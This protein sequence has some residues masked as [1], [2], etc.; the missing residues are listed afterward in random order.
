MDQKDISTALSIVQ[1]FTKKSLNEKKHKYSKGALQNLNEKL[2]IKKDTKDLR[3]AVIDQLFNWAKQYKKA[4]PSAVDKATEDLKVYS[5]S[6]GRF[7]IEI[8]EELIDN[9]NKIVELEALRY[10]SHNASPIHFSY[11]SNRIMSLIQ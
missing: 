9:P 2:G 11:I 5:K 6:G 7:F 10:L 1:N 3:P 8:A 4:N